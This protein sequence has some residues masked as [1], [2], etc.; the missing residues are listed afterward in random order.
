MRFSL[1]AEIHLESE[2]TDGW[3][4]IPNATESIKRVISPG[5]HHISLKID[6][7]RYRNSEYEN[8][9]SDFRKHDAMCITVKSKLTIFNDPKSSRY[10]YLEMPSLYCFFKTN[11]I[12]YESLNWSSLRR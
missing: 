12:Q 3:F 1:I 10:C 2:N 4:S 9:Q 8:Q 6:R 11:E 7:S 5:F